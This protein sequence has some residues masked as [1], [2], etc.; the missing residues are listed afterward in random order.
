MEDMEGKN[1]VAYTIPQD[2]DTTI[3]AFTVDNRG[4]IYLALSNLSSL[5]R[6]DNIQGENQTLLNGYS[7]TTVSLFAA[8]QNR[9]YL[10]QNVG[11]GV[12]LRCLDT[13]T[14]EQIGSLLCTEGNL[15][16]QL[17]RPSSICVDRAGRIYIAD[18]SNH[19]IVRMDDLTGKNW[20]TLETY[21]TNR[22]RFLLPQSVFVDNADHIYVAQSD[23]IV[24]MDDITGRNPVELHNNGENR[25]QA[26]GAVWVDAYL[27]I[28]VTDGVYK[29][30]IHTER[31]VRVDD[32]TGRGW[33]NYGGSDHF[34]SPG[35]I[36]VR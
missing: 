35:H 8:G 17:T 27:R 24:R 14:R 13:E 16:K 32:M 3:S 23:R 31:L 22:R 26:V 11:T 12:M 18:T 20:V 1:R 30:G 36:I 34:N 6:L 28:Y 10:M 29:G 25:F 33:C 5:L 7:G 2:G 19:R 15:L 21:G 9:L 4:R